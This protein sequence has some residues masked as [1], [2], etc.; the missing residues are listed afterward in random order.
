MR[1]LSNFSLFSFVHSRTIIDG[2][3]IKIRKYN[4]YDQIRTERRRRVI[5]TLLWFAFSL[6]LALVV[7]DIDSAISLIGGLAATF[8]FV[9]PGSCLFSLFSF[10]FCIQSIEY[11]TVKIVIG[12]ARILMGL[13]F[14]F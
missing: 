5:E 9:F 10:F 13:D 12:Q 2:V 7:P 6:L 1:V 8:I 11:Y 14:K 3:V 4:E